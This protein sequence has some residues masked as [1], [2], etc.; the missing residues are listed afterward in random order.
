MM[1]VGIHHTNKFLTSRFSVLLTVG[2]TLVLTTM[3]VT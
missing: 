3:I 2:V 1:V